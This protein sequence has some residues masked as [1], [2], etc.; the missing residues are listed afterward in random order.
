[1]AKEREEINN[2]LRSR[3]VEAQTSKMAVFEVSFMSLASEPY[4]FAG[5][6]LA[7]YNTI[8]KFLCGVLSIRSSHNPVRVPLW[9]AV[10]F[11]PRRCRP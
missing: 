6:D 9:F 1:M 3:A 7:G 2:P 11:P 5:N 10:R 8:D 4:K